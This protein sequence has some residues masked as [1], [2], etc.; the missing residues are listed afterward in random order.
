MVL[1]LLLAPHLV[2]CQMIQNIE[3]LATLLSIGEVLRS[4]FDHEI[5][6][7][8]LFRS[9]SNKY[10]NCPSDTPMFIYKQQHVLV[11]TDHL[12]AYLLHGAESFL[13]S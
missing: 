5:F 13:R 10:L 2:Q 7:P 1:Y 3:L 9:F 12:R 11:T 6:Y 8:K 4:L